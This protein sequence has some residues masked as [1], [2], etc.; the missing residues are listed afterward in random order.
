MSCGI[1]FIINNTMKIQYASDLHLEFAE[2]KSF[3]EHGGIEPMGDVLVLAGD[4]SY[5][6]DRNMIKRRFFDWCADHFR[7]TFIVP[8]NHE[9][10]GGYD[11]VQ[12][13]EDFEYAYRDNVTYL[14]NKSVVLDDTELFFTTLW[15]RISPL[16]LWTIQGG[17]NDFRYGRLEGTRFCAN[18]VDDLHR[19]CKDWL[20]VAL[21]ASTV[22]HKVVVTHHCPTLRSEFNSYPGGA[23]NSAFQVDMD[24][25]IGES[26]V[27]YWVYGHTHYSGGSGTMIGNTTLLCNQMGYVF[28]NEHLGFDGKACIEM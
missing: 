19:R 28:Q 11:I 27:D 23:L 25:F 15:T 13:M 21:K 3:I 17:M 20:S 9:F 10:Y 4:V 14:N 12:T 18:D 7:E 16:H 26:G 22:G 8:G 2:N 1:T 5:L 24:A 6:G